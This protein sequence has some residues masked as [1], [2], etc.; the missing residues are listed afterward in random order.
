MQD[1]YITYQRWTDGTITITPEEPFGTFDEIIEELRSL[2]DDGRTVKAIKISLKEG[3]V[4]DV[5]SNVIEALRDLGHY[6]TS[7]P[8]IE[9]LAA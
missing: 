8:L 3:T 4:T 7:H 9:G 6:E 2:E 1:H 5:T